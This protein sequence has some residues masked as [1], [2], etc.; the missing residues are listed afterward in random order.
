MTKR[1]LTL[2]TFCLIINI[3][4]TA[5]DLPLSDGEK[6]TIGE[7][8]VTGNTTYN[9]ETVIAYTGLKKG[10]EIYI[11]GDKISSIIKKLWDLDQFSDI[12]FYITNIDNGV[13]D[14]ELEITEVPKLSKIRI[15]GVKKRKEEELLEENKI[16]TGMKVTENLRTTTKNYIENKYREDGYF[17]AKVVVNTSE[18]KSDTTAL[19]TNN[20]VN[21]VVNV[22]KGD[23]VKISDI[24]FIGNENF[25]NWKLK[26]SL[27]N[28]KQKNFLRFWKRSKYVPEEYS[29]DKENLIDKYKERGYRDARIVSDSLIEVD[30]KNIALKLNIAEGDQYY[31]GDID[32][33]GNSVYSDQQLKNRLGIN[34]GDIYNGVLMDE[35][36]EDR[37][38]PNAEDI[39]NMY[40][41][42]GYLFSTIDL[43][44]TNVYNDTID[45]EVRIQEGKEAYFNEIRVTG[46]DKTKDHVIYRELRT[47]PGQ[48]YSQEDVVATVRELGQLGF[49]D[50]E[51]LEPQ[52][53]DPNPQTGTLD[54]EYNVVEAGASQIELQGGYGGGGFIGTLGLSFNNFALSGIFDK[55][56]YKPL[57][58]GDGQTL[59]LR[60]QA[61][62]FYQ[63][64]SMS[65]QEP[66]LGGEK[67]VS[68]QT[69]FSYTRQ[70]NFDYGTYR[71]DRSRSFDI[72]G[73]NVGLAKRL[74]VPDP[75]IT[76]SHSLG[77]QR[78]NLNNYNTGLFSFGDGNSNS[79]TYTFGLTR[80]NTYVNPIFPTGGSKFKLT[81]KFT[82]P[83]SL[84]NSVDYENLDQQREFQLEDE[85]GNL[86][87]EDGARVTPE[88]AVGDQ[89]KIDQEKFKWLEYYKVK[90][91]GE[92]FT[93]IYD[94][95]V[96][97]TNAEYGFLGA[98]NSSRG[99]P[100]FERYF[101]GGD[102]LGAFSMDGREN[103]QLRGYPNNQVTPID[104]ELQTQQNTNLGTDG[105]TIYNKYSLELRYPI[106]LKPSASIYA[107][108][109]LEAGATF[110]DFRNFNPF[111][112][113]RSAG[114][115]IRIFMPAFGLLGIDFGY[116]FDP[117]PGSQG[118]NGW[119]THFIIGQQF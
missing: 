14:L 46:N 100:P 44:E 17:N 96:L 65:F 50:A 97:R 103:I 87:D 24:D 72:M 2:I 93:Q 32:F 28:T 92:W 109:F 11:P 73:V 104:R 31:I 5:Q 6:Y 107:L 82:P 76:V 36:I 35:R 57:P 30:N 42:N 16:R 66:W 90:F 48:K 112:V 113:N 114:A 38:D 1:I 101:L 55:D 85:N 99:I 33:I 74:T 64:Y 34:K 52:F 86:I 75:Y 91:S 49:F 67:P 43:V 89:G 115:G 119:E 37:T 81:A 94:K 60:A 84:W 51:Q 8:I 22:D 71:A 111:Q 70:F 10:E 45:F 102:G 68:L 79:L 26:R 83:Y 53:I 12:N 88:N 77:F 15:Q 61:S 3:S 63:T 117:V 80:D 78:Y 54:L 39:A 9:E 29:K 19:K 108:T 41:N 4:A 7:I 106:T 56:A 25:S 27:K 13:A 58:M 110:D 116:G 47:K 21:M 98:Y 69:S 95:L 23:R 62:T 20:L 18:A 40:K 118:P 105:A 59:S